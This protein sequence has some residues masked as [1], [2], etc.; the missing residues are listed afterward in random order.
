MFFL[1]AITIGCWGDN[2]VAGAALGAG[3]ERPV[4]LFERGPSGWSRRPKAIAHKVSSLGLG[5]NG[6][7]LVLTMQCFWGDCGSERKRRTIGPP[8]HTLSTS[9]LAH[10]T[11]GMFRLVDPDDRVPIDTEYRQG[12][13]I[14][15]YGTHAGVVGDP[16]AHKDPHS[17]YRATIVGDR[18]VD[19]QLMMTGPGLADPAPIQFRGDT[20]L[21]LTTQPGRAIGM[22]Q[23]SPLRIT[24]TWSGV[25]VPHAMVVGDEIWL[26]AQ[27]VRQGKMVPVRSISR[28]GA[29]S[30]TDWQTPLPTDDIAGC[31]NPVGGVFRG[32]PLVF[33]V[34]EKIGGHP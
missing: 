21:F 17:I 8:V 16:A 3:D 1:L 7:Q 23:G 5:I 11:P 2:P 24:K 18:I 25:S 19:P 9:D 10:F 32:T 33:C 20:L 26:W 14:W 28:D 22:A 15:Y 12:G 6:D 4:W 29:Q 27:Q 30:W 31:G 34:T 13:A